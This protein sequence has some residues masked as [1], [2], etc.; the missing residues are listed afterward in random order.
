LARAVSQQQLTE[1]D[2]SQ[3]RSPAILP[4]ILAKQAQKA[5]GAY[6]KGQKLMR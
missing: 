5:F 4:D 1:S 2:D 3:R 6:E